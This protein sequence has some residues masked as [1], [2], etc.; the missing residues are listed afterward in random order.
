MPD[1]SGA[2]GSLQIEDDVV[3]TALQDGTQAT[4]FMAC[5]GTERAMAP[6]FGRGQVEMIDEG[7]RRP[8]AESA[9][10]AVGRQQG[11][12]GRFYNPVDDPAGMGLAQRGY[13]R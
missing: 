12:P 4:D 9:G 3:V 10:L 2:D 6:G 5:F 11:T 7:L 1:H 8:A 13:R